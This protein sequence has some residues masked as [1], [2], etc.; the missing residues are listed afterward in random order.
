MMCSNGFCGGRGKI[1]AM[2]KQKARAHCSINVAI[3]IFLMNLFYGEEKTN[4][5]SNLDFFPKLLTMDI[6]LK[7][8]STFTFGAWCHSSRSTF[9]F[10]PSVRS[11]GYGPRDPK[12]SDDGGEIPKSQG[13]GW[14][15]QS[16]LWNLLFTWLKKLPCGQLPY[17]FWR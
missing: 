14:E 10:T 7:K 2:V 12:L 16:W 15:F 8:I 4:K 9:G 13:R 11:K 5:W 17:V 1:G 3:I 6:Y